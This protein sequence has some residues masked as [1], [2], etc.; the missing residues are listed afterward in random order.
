MMKISKIKNEMN[1]TSN[2]KNGTETFS[3]MKFELKKNNKVKRKTK[4]F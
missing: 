1:E 3:T 4:K 2:V